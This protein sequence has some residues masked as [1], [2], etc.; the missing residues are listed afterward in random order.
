MSKENQPERVP[1]KKPT[2]PP[3]A[4]F[5]MPPAPPITGTF[6]VEGGEPVVKSPGQ[7][8]KPPPLGAPKWTAADAAVK[9]LE[10]GK[11]LQKLPD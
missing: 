8:V 7:G 4:G 5:V 10:E 3:P 6:G 9:A 1:P 11:P 2:D